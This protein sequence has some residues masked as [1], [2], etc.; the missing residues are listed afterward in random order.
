MYHLFVFWKRRRRVRKRDWVNKRITF[1]FAYKGINISGKFSN[2]YE[3]KT[4]FNDVRRVSSFFKRLSEERK[5]LRVLNARKTWAYFG[6]II[7]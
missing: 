7:G 2:K 4:K 6:E 1:R 5:R 3:K